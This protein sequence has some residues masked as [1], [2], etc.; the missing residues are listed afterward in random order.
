MHQ[1]ILMQKIK[2]IHHVDPKKNASQKDG[3][4]DTWKVEQD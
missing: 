2:K 3:Q 4:T 1:N